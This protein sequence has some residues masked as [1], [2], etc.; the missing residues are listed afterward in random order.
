MPSTR[1]ITR[2][3][4]KKKKNRRDYRIETIMRIVTLFRSTVYRT[5]LHVL[6]I[7]FFEFNTK[8]PQN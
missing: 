7:F 3:E 8:K 5:D 4:L 2:A 1:I 6:Y